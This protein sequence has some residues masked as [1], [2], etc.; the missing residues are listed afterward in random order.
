MCVLSW[1]SNVI[2]CIISCFSSSLHRYTLRNRDYDDVCEELVLML[3]DTLSGE[4]SEVGPED[5][6]SGSQLE[7]LQQALTEQVT[8]CISQLYNP[9]YHTDCLWLCGFKFYEA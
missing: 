8:T 3:T 2:Y 4:L 7:E 6:L 1:L 5:V 9:L